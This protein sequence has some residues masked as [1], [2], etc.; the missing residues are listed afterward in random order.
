MVVLMKCNHDLNN[1]NHL[2]PDYCSDNKQGIRGEFTET[3]LIPGFRYV[4]PTVNT[5]SKLFT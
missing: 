4:I 3:S 5:G 1:G 2:H